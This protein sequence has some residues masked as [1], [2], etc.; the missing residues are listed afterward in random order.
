M[1]DIEAASAPQSPGEV[2]ARA[3]FTPG[4]DVAP[5]RL[6]PGAP[7]TPPPPSSHAAT[8]EEFFGFFGR[9]APRQPLPPCFLDL[10]D[11][12]YLRLETVK[13]VLL[14]IEEAR[15]HWRGR[16]EHV[17]FDPTIRMLREHVVERTGPSWSL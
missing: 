8:P 1:S 5:Q 13:M 3:R 4:K 2:Y 10:V 11:C 15:R 9:L 12:R 7:P 17:N 6:P 16:G 14:D